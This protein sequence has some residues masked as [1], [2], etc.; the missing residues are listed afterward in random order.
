MKDFITLAAERYSVRKFSDKKV[1]PEIVNG[2]LEAA[3]VSPTACN[4]QPQKIFV[5]E[6]DASLE[7]LKK[8]TSCHFDAPLAFIICYDKNISWKRPFDGADSGFV[9]GSIVTT[10]MMLEGWDKGVGSTWVMYFDPAAVAEQF[11][12]P[13]NIVP[14]AILPMGYPADDAKPAAMHSRFRPDEETVIRL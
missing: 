6:S 9:D 14:V 4:N 10:H 13:E 7:K 5:L 3:K 1:A 11:G 12:L 8:C 2:I